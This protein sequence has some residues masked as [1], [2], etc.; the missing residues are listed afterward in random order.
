MYEIYGTAAGADD[1]YAGAN[2]GQHVEND[3]NR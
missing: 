2:D 3:I 1:D